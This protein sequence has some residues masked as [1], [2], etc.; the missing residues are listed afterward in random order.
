MRKKYTDLFNFVKK[1]KNFFYFSVSID[2][3]HEQPIE[4]DFLSVDAT[5][6]NCYE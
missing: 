1:V 5:H 3:S 2:P 4:P 6:Y